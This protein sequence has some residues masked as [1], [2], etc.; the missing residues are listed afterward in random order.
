MI[1][2]LRHVLATLREHRWCVALPCDDDEM[3][4]TLVSVTPIVLVHGAWHGAW[5]WAAVQAELDKRGVP[6]YAV[7]LPGHGTSDRPLGDLHGDAA[8]VADLIDRLATDVVL[9]GHSYG[10]A[11]IT[12]AATRTQRV[13]HLVYLTAFVLDEGESLASI[14]ILA[15][16]PPQ[17]IIG[18]GQA[19]RTLEDGAIALDPAAAIPALYGCCEPAV[20]QASAARLSPQP[21]ASFAQA[22]TGASWK[23]VPSTYVR[24]TEDQVIPLAHQD[25]MAQRCGTVLTLETDHSPAASMPAATADILARVARHTTR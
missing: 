5:C 15:A 11:V 9:V 7:D 3:T 4:D 8:C 23:R 18:L 17:Q 6:S 10:G 2:T 12:E 1:T 24:C 20:Q 19:R 25:A 21:K 14:P 13:R 16:L 22:V